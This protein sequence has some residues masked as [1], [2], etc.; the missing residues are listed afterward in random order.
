MEA[1]PRGGVIPSIRKISTEYRINPLIVSKAYQSLVDEK[2]IE[3][4][5]ELE[6]LSNRAPVTTAFS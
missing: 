4:S 3:N 6:W 2:V 1:I 5:M